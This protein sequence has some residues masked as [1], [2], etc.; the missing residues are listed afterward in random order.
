[1]DLSS[2]L[3]G[4]LFSFPPPPRPF[5]FLS[6][7]EITDSTNDNVEADTIPSK[8]TSSTVGTTLIF[9]MRLFTALHLPFLSLTIIPRLL[10]QW[11]LY[12]SS[13]LFLFL[14]MRVKT[15]TM[16]HTS[17]PWDLALLRYTGSIKTL[18]GRS[19]WSTFLT[20]QKVT[21]LLHLSSLYAM[22]QCTTYTQSL[23]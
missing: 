14:L 7:S 13:S 12:G 2:I 4:N 3:R 6:F 10:Q 23:H 15:L 5:S 11:C 20:T 21:G 16:A 9:N 8:S 1:M 17:N 18:Q 19:N 22:P